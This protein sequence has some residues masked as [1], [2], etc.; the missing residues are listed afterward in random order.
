MP[1]DDSYDKH[2]LHYLDSG[3]LEITWDEIASEAEADEE[4]LAV[5]N[6][7][8]SGH[9]PERLRRYEAEKHQL[10][11]LGSMVFK[12]ENIVLPLSLRERAFQSAHQGHVGIAS[13]KKILREYFWWPN[14]STSAEEFVRNCETC[15]LLSRKNPPLPLTSRRLPN[16]PWE[17]LQVDFFTDRDFGKGEFLVLVDTYSRYLYVVEMGKT[18]ADSTNAVLMK[19]FAEWGLPLVI[20]SDNG[21]PFQSDNFVSTWEGKG[22]KVWKSIPLSAQSN[23]AVERQNS[24]IKNALAAARLDGQDWK[25]ALQKYV[26]VHNKIRPLSRFG[27]TPFEL[28]V[29]WKFRGTFPCLWERKSDT[30]LDRQAVTEQDNYSKLQSKKYADHRRGAKYSDINPGDTV[31][32]TQQKKRKSDPVFGTERYTV[33]TRENAKLVVKSSRGVQ[34]T[35]HVDEVK[36]VPEKKQEED[37]ANNTGGTNNNNEDLDRYQQCQ[38]PKRMPKQPEKLKDMILY[39]IFS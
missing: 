7:I 4:L 20:Q 5:K 25:T 22:V 18:D 39:C 2:L 8:I 19:I 28:L 38:R 11:W 32:I 27:V 15:L 31:V 9:W 21:P 37:I 24:G 36:R 30:S 16:G 35:R 3:K 26:H 14:M 33:V 17:V 34:L 13:V 1:F 12:S 10:R 6:A 23:G 29:G